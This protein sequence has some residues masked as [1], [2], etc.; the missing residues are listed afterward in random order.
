MKAKPNA[1]SVPQGFTLRTDLG[2][3]RRLVFERGRDLRYCPAFKKWLAWDGQRFAIDETDQV[4]RDAKKVASGLFHAAL[5]IEDQDRRKSEMS[6]AMKSESAARIKAMVELAKSE[7]EMVVGPSDLDSDRWK[8]NV[9]NGVVDLKSGRL[10]PSDRK[11]LH[12]K[13]VDVEYDSNAVARIWDGFLDTITGGDNDLAKFLQRAVGYSLTGDTRE[14]ALFLLHGSGSNGKTT[15]LEAVRTITGD[16]AAQAD[17]TSFLKQ[18]NDRVR[19]DIARLRGARFVSAVEPD[20]GQR[21]DESVVKQLTGGDR[22]SARFLYGEF[23]EFNPEFKI[24]LAA[25]HLPEV[26]GSDDG[27]WRRLVAV[28][29]TVKIPFSK[30]D[31]D[32]GRKLQ[33]ESPGILAW[34]VRGCLEWQ[35]I[36][37]DKPKRVL[38]SSDEYR[39]VMDP[40]ATFSK[41]M[42]DTGPGYRCSFNELKVAYADW[43]EDEGHRPMNARQFGQRLTELGFTGTRGAKGIAMRQDINIR[44][45]FQMAPLVTP[46]RGVVAAGA[47]D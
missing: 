5:D 39:Q 27:I 6:H 25:N 40:V 11:Q 17:F 37:L 8:L 20:A 10:G 35:R 28:P 42:C 2:N 29:F 47:G 7:I 12:T 15:F 34:A 26:H 44:P 19:N 21:L 23:F 41:D 9:A 14:Q 33:E 4:M 24:W 43:A 46:S 22:I 3:A 36:G 30:L 18:D 16:Y 1:T 38:D 13:V 45:P 32:L 31:R